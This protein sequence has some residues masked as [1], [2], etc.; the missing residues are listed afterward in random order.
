M[1]KKEV[2][3]DAFVRELLK[4]ANISLTEQGCDMWFPDLG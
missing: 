4:E 2:K 3:T 1:A